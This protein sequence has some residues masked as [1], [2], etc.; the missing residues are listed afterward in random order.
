MPLPFDA[1]L[2]D[3]VAR[4]PA[5]YGREFDL[6][7][8]VPL[9][10][11]NVDLSTITAATDV[12]LGRG[13][14][15]DAL[16]DINFQSAWAD[17]LLARILLYNALLHYRYRVAVHSVVVLLRPLANDLRLDQGLHYAVWPERGR[18]DLSFEVVRLWERPV[19]RLLEGGL[20]TLPLAPLGQVPPGTNREEALPDILRR[21]G[22]RLTQ[23]AGPEETG[24]LWMATF[25]LSGL[26]L[27][28][29][30]LRQLFQG[31]HGMKESSGY[32]IILDEGR[33]EGAVKEAKKILLRLGQKRFG[34]PGQ[35][36]TMALDAIND[37][38]RLE[39]MTDRVLD[40]AGWQELLNTP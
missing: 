30:T 14:P 13:D 2:K 15:P 23:E 20:G 8:P 28:R 27:S 1:T 32:Q 3:L 39:R 25:V 34:P 4:F 11:L 6:A 37:L 22:E 7:G 21:I 36:I 35:E 18:T 26:I 31:V 9:V 38:E 17:D 24:K 29:E 40:V 10:A 16:I 5:D 33:A 19:E 12:V